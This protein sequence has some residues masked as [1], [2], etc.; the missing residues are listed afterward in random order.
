MLSSNALSGQHRWGRQVAHRSALTVKASPSPMTPVFVLRLTVNSGLR[1]L[2]AGTSLVVQW[3]RL[4]LPVQELQVLSL[5]S[6]LRSHVPASR[7]TKTDNKNNIVR[8]SMNTY[9]MIHIKK[10]SWKEIQKLLQASLEKDELSS[11]Y[12]SQGWVRILVVPSRCSQ[13]GPFS[14]SV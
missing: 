2:R 10:K 11:L 13:I 7:K 14:H 12:S 8:N 4:C 9:K 5:V 3:L 1:H 6:E